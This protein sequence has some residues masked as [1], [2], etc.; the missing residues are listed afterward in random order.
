MTMYRREILKGGAASIALTAVPAAVRAADQPARL[1]ALF[2]DLVQQQLRQS[3][4]YATQLGLD[5]GPNADLRA[6]LSD[7]S[8]AGRAQARAQT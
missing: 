8:A 7:Q 5:K 6:K 2:D 1:S 3:P 4:E